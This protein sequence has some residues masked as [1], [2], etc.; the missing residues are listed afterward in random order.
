MLNKNKEPTQMVF[1]L[2][3]YY[4]CFQIIYLQLKRMKMASKVDC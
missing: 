2:K 3:F 1:V 4:F